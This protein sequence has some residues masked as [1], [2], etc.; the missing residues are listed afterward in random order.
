MRRK[1]TELADWLEAS[2]QLMDGVTVTGV[3]IDS[4]H[5]QP[6]DLFIP[7]RGDQVNGHRYVQ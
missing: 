7:F 2:G 1:L 6:G 3:T 5:I 4:R